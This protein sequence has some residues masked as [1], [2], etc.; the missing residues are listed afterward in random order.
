MQHNDKM[1]V[2]SFVLPCRHVTN[3]RADNRQFS[4]VLKIFGEGLTFDDVLLM[5]AYSEVYREM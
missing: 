5:P 2:T 4:P 1:P 3:Q